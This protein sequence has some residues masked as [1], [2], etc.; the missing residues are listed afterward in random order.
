MYLMTAGDS[1]S[2]GFSYIYT[3]FAIF[4]LIICYMMIDFV[5]LTLR[6]L[7]LVD[8]SAASELYHVDLSLQI[9]LL[10]GI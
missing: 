6:L 5:L 8:V 4:K 2:Y 10:K 7:K 3:V 9:D 1:A